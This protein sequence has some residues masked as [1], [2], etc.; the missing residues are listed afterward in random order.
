M[1]FSVSYSLS[2]TQD[3]RELKFFNIE[4]IVQRQDTD[5]I[6]L[7]LTSSS[8]DKTSAKAEEEEDTAAVGTRALVFSRFNILE[9]VIEKK[10]V[11]VVATML[12]NSNFNVVDF[13]KVVIFRFF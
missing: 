11:F 12:E 8:F 7:L 10:I 4:Q 5:E 13:Q 3:S 2:N 6:F 9:E 1:F